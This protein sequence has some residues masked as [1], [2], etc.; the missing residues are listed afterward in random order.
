MERKS[1]YRMISLGSF[2]STNST[3][4]TNLP[5]CLSLRVHLI[6][7][8]HVQLRYSL[9][10]QRTISLK[11]KKKRK[12]DESKKAIL[13][14]KSYFNSKKASLKNL[15]LDTKWEADNAFH[16]R[17]QHGWST[18]SSCH[19]ISLQPGSNKKLRSTWVF[20]VQY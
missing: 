2:Q 11:N 1:F 20:K 10:R 13:Y 17:G 16:E 15:H 18:G 9:G 8:E 14:Y 6:E 4:F 3:L 5:A 19:M 12:K 7:F